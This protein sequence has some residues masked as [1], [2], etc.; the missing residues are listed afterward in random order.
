MDDNAVH[1]QADLRA[2]YR[3]PTPAVVHKARP[4]V[5]PKAAAFLASSPL[6]VLATTSASGT[7]ASPRGGPPGFVRVL[8]E[9]HVAFAD[10]SGNNRLDSYGNIVEHPQVGM[11]FFV[12]GEGETLRINGR[13]SVTTDPE[14]LACTAVDGVRPKVAVVV[15]VE[16][17]YIHCAKAIRRSGV[18]DPSTWLSADERT[19]GAEVI[20]DQF[21]LDVDPATV[22]ANLEQNYE[23][24]LWVEGGR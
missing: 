16:E 1:D 17:C 3:D 2:R 24:T 19:T 11:I 13:A 7:D 12:P 20:V 9:H 23:E 18:W 5:D 15:D 22:A 21:D 10:L 4:C 8:D 14:V 6:L